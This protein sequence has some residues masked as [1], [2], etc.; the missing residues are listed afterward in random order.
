[1]SQ[2]Q[3]HSHQQGPNTLQQNAAFLLDALYCSEEHLEEEVMQDF[4]QEQEE[5]D[6][7]YYNNAYE[8]DSPI[9]ILEQDPFWEDEELISLLAKEQQNQLHATLQTDP[10]LSGPRGDAVEWMFKVVAYYSFSALTAVLAVDYLDRFLASF[11]FQK[12]KPW[13]IQLTAVAC[14]S[15][16]AKVEETQVPLLLD[17]QVSRLI[18]LLSL[19][20]S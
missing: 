9:T 14:L 16:A 6:E 10:S 13:T 2:Q 5:I 15:L 7:S 12:E 20:E 17:L 19:V 4:F 1:M 18:W 3:H 11:H 8:T